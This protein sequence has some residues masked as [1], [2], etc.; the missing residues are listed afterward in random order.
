VVASGYKKRAANMRCSRPLKASL[1]NAGDVTYNS[2]KAIPG[3]VP[4]E[5]ECRKCIPC[6]L[7]I[8]REKAIRCVHEAE[9]HEGNI[10]LTLTYNEESLES[11]WLDYKHFQDF[12]KRL[13]EKHGRSHFGKTGGISYMVTGE[14]GELTKRPHWHAIIF[15]YWPKDSELWRTNDLGHKIYISEEISGLWKKG[16]IEFGTV[17]MESAGYV[18][19]YAA[20][21]LVH[22]KDGEH[23]YDPIHKTSSRRAIG[24]S[25][26]EKYWKQTF[27][28]GFVVSKENGQEMKIPRYYKDW[29]KKY[30]FDEY[31]KYSTGIGNEIAKKAEA[32]ARK[33]EIEY[34]SSMMSA[35]KGVYPLKRA[36]VKE[37]ILGRKFKRLQEKLK[38]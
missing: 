28:N 6:R 34:I 29:L 36:R 15:N 32:K 24:R 26:I 5:I 30:K 12:M 23:D 22:G 21:K 3:L 20:K 31:L 9:M 18:A 38:L 7:N 4:F 8:A 10:F 19:R 17:T 35:S 25:W 13:R 33:E 1:D 2:R 14:Y 27:E 37:Q 11:P 16:H